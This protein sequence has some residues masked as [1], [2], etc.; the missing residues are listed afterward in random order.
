MRG[1]GKAYLERFP[2]FVRVAALN[3][4]RG[5]NVTRVGND[6]IPRANVLSS[7]SDSRLIDDVGNM[8]DNVGIGMPFFNNLL[9]FFERRFGAAEDVDGAGTGLGEGCDDFS[10]YP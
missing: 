4:F 2:P 6:D 3:G 1:E 10:A 8:Q 5:G 9:R 7:R